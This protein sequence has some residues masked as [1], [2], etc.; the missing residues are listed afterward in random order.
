VGASGLR[1]LQDRRVTG[2]VV[3]R[4]AR[5]EDAELL[6]LLA[7]QFAT[8]FVPE[9]P[10]FASGVG[11]ASNR[12]RGCGSGCVEGRLPLDVS[13]RRERSAKRHGRSGAAVGQ[14]MVR[15]AGAVGGQV[16]V[17]VERQSPLVPI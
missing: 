16:V 4:P 12:G 15:V 5:P 2:P 14:S 6:F 17:G 11:R 10:T 9:Q 1:L 3:V 7:L 8:S 13:V